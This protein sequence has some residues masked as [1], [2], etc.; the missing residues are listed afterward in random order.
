MCLWC[1]IDDA[2]VALAAASCTKFRQCWR[3]LPSKR[4]WIE[5][6]FSLL[7]CIFFVHVSLVEETAHRL[8]SWIVKSFTVK[9]QAVIQRYFSLGYSLELS[10]RGYLFR[11]TGWAGVKNDPKFKFPVLVRRI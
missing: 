2:T 7:D 4:E 10:S 11:S 3:S 9:Q 8:A 5:S 1:H 6:K